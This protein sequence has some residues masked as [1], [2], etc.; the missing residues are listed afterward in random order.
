MD[1]DAY[2]QEK[3]H[4]KGCN[5]YL[6]G[7]MTGIEDWNRTAFDKAEELLVCE[8]F[9]VVWI[10]NPADHI[11][12]FK[13][14]SHEMAIWRSI[15]SL[16]GIGSTKPLAPYYDLLVSLPGWEKSAG[17]TLEREVAIACGIEVCELAEVVE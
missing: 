11:D 12:E 1:T 4:V 5:V 7:P 10:Y 3:V 9:N 16:V 15:H 17:A 6:S 8:P 2:S 14:L 13:G